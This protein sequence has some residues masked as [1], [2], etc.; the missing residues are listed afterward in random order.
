MQNLKFCEKKLTIFKLEP[1]TR[2]MLQHVVTGWPNVC[3][4]VPNN[5]ATCCVEMLRAFGRGFT[6]KKPSRED[7]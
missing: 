6:S 2:N 1:T 7:D 4:F 3:N 5:V